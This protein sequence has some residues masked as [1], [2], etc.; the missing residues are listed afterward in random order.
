MAGR[1][2]GT[3]GA[4]DRGGGRDWP[5]D[6]RGLCLPRG[7]VRRRDRHRRL[8]RA[9]RPRRRASASSM[10]AARPRRSEALAGEIGPVDILFNCAGFVHHGTVLTHLGRRLG[11]LVRSQRQVDAPDDPRLS[12]AHAGEGQGSIVNVASGASSVRAASPTAT[13]TAARRPR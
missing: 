12:A 2:A 5:R 7:R 4:T 13:S 3:G 11:L 8:L 6:G 1:L 9:R 10:S